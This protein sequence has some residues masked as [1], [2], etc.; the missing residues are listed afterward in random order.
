MRLFLQRSAVFFATVA[1]LLYHVSGSIFC[2]LLFAFVHFL[3][4]FSHLSQFI[5][6]TVSVYFHTCLSSFLPLSQFS[7]LTCTFAISSG[8]NFRRV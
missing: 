5:F 2:F 3:R 8:D 7:V 4:F 6:A 1:V